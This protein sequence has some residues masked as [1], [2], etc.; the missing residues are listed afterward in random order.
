MATGATHA[1]NLRMVSSYLDP[2]N[3]NN[4]AYGFA[5]RCVFAKKTI[6]LMLDFFFTLYL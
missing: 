3:N 5:L 1:Y 2:Q 4:Q 6:G